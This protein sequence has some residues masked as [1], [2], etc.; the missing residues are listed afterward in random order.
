[1]KIQE[2]ADAGLRRMAISID[3]GTATT[4]DEFRQETGSFE[5]TITAARMV[6]EIGLPLQINTTVCA[7]T[8]DELSEIKDLV[9]ELGAVLWSVFFLVPVGRG[10]V[11]D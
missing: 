9:D 5:Q 8:V 2:L 1:T 7:E 3:G 4:H 11:L 10:D 6:Q